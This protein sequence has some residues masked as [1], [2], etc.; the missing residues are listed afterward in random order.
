MADTTDETAA[1]PLLKNRYRLGRVLGRGGMC[2][3]YQAWDTRLQRNVAVKRLEPPLNE[4]PR[5]RARFDREGRALAQLSHPNLVTLID[6]GSTENEDYLVFEYVE[7]RSLKELTRDG[8]LGDAEM[9]Q[10]AGQVA[11]GLSAAHLAGIVHRDVKPQNILIDSRGHAKVTDFGIATGADWTKVTR[12]GSIIGSARYMSPEQVRSKPVDAR[13]DVYSLG[14]VMYEM[15]AGHPPFDGT[16]MPE[17]ARR[18]L[19]D[20]PPPLSDIRG[21]LPTGLERVVMRCLEKLPEDRFVSMDELLG[22]LVGLGLYAP[23]R[24]PEVSDAHRRQHRRGGGEG[25]G[26]RYSPA[27]ASFDSGS[28]RAQPTGD[29]VSD[30]DLVRAR[31]RRQRANRRWKILGA[32]LAVLVILAVVLTLTLSGGGAPAV[33]GLS[34]D[35]ARALA[36]DAGMQVEV[37]D[38]VPT[39]D[40]P[41][42]T[43]L[44]QDPAPEVDSSDDV[45][46]LTVTR[47]PTPVSVL[48]LKDAD[49]E[50]DNTEHPDQL[51]RLIDG[52]E[53]TSWT[54]E[55]YRSSAFGN[56]KSGVGLDF[57]LEEPA[58]IV[59]IVSPV[60]GWK[61]ELL[62]EVSSGPAA[63]LA[64]LDGDS[65]QIIT[66][67]EGLTSG[68]VWFTELAQLT[69]GKWGVEI[70]EMRFYR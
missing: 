70:S 28:G 2:I 38:Q 6:R 50:G 57:T 10:I 34:L 59:E 65:N 46:R 69:E 63:R 20:A 19:Y 39:F 48:D 51:A 45:L 32:V 23:Q 49:P 5:T 18:H 7:G 31:A 40:K 64:T 47:E 54:T 17:I 26:S 36:T 68:R 41:A 44:E 14:V 24:A 56:L 53:S 60:E 58:S 62:Q 8:P 3:V 52:K 1:G 12:A 61:G 30:R 33:V 21:D 55:L 25:R 67:R 42:G 13:S 15:L 43:V 22:A 11:E 37:A 9:G 66:L 35:Q 29:F 4:D 16:N 27:G